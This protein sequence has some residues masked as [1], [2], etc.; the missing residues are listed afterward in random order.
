MEHSSNLPVKDEVF[1]TSPPSEAQRD[2]MEARFFVFLDDQPIMRVDCMESL[3]ANEFAELN[4]TEKPY[5]IAHIRSQIFYAVTLNEKLPVGYTPRNLRDARFADHPTLF[6]LISRAIQITRFHRAQT[7]C[8]H[9]EG[10]MSLEEISNDWACSNCAKVRYP[11]IAPCVIV[12]VTRGEECL[13]ARR[14]K[15]KHTNYSLLAGFIEAGESAEHALVRE[16]REEVGIEVKNIQYFGSQT[17]PFPNQLML[18]YTAE[19]ESEDIVLETEEL[20][21]G[22]WYHHTNMPK[23]PGNETIAGQLIRH[24]LSQFV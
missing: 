15:A 4:C 7:L 9:C 21:D 23:F 24:F 2:T 10:E 12:L 17:W 1:A 13:L 3:S 22:G 18:G 14:R 19:W 20:S 6:N 11:T 16:V 8:T 5:Y